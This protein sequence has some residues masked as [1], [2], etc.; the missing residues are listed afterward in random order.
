MRCPLCETENPED[1][2]ECATCGRQL[3]TD[4]QVLEEVMPIPGLEETIRDP[5]ESVVGAI[6]IMPELERTMIARRDLRV[7][8]EHVP[9]VEGTMLVEDPTVP[10]NWTP[11]DVELDLGREVDLDPRTA[12][13]EDGG[14]CVWCGAESDGGAVCDTCGRRRSRYSGPPP[15][16]A[17]TQSKTD[18]TVLCPAC[19]SRVAIAPRCEECGVRFAVAET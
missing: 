4:A 13:P 11:G 19:F 15:V 2:A 14:P 9:G 18:E 1:V 6:E 10:T 16:A 12:V 7:Q 17:Q 8:E 5:M 3:H